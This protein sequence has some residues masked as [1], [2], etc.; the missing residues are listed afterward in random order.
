MHQ[1]QKVFVNSETVHVTIKSNLNTS[2][3]VLKGKPPA[4]SVQ[5]KKSGKKGVVV[6]QK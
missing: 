5:Q 3:Q 6:K 4:K 2:T 1:P